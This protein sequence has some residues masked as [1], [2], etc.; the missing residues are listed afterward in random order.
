MELELTDQEI[1]MVSFLKRQLS[2]YVQEHIQDLQFD[3]LSRFTQSLLTQVGDKNVGFKML[4]WDVNTQILTGIIEFLSND[5]KP[6]KKIDFSIHCYKDEVEL[7][8][9]LEKIINECEPWRKTHPE[10]VEQ[11]NKLKEKFNNMSGNFNP[12]TQGF[13]A[14]VTMAICVISVVGFIVWV[15]S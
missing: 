4:G 9:E 8:T 12:E 3:D 6:L 2:S 15:L 5:G 10:W 13:G 1:G 11:E 7:E 14:W